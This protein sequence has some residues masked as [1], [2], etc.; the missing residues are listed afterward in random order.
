MY[1]FTVVTVV[2]SEQDCTS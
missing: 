2:H 1:K